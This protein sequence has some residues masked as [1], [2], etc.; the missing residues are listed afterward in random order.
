MGTWTPKMRLHNK[1]K[2]LKMKYRSSYIW[3]KSY[4]TLK[5]VSIVIAAA[6]TAKHI[7]MKAVKTM[8]IFILIVFIM[9]AVMRRTIMHIH[10]LARKNID[11]SW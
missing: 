1:M 4:F 6:R 9:A 2:K 8:E 5:K 3:A 7:T 10:T 11:N